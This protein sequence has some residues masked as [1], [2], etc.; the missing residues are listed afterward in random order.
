M[1]TSFSKAFT[2]DI[3]AFSFCNGI[4]KKRMTSSIAF[5]YNKLQNRDCFPFVY[6]TKGLTRFLC[7]MLAIS[8]TPTLRGSLYPKPLPN[9]ISRSVV[10]F[11][12]LSK[13]T[14]R[15]ASRPAK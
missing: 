13:P 7:K 5:M 8:G 11:W 2:N 12:V 10:R 6:I 9:S 15:S 3:T 4:L 1:I 14:K